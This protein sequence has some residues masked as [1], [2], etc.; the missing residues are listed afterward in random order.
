MAQ[1][2]DRL[3]PF[4]VAMT[5]RV[6]LAKL[7][8]RKHL[9]VTVNGSDAVRQNWVRGKMTAYLDEDEEGTRVRIHA[10]LEVL[11]KLAS[12]G[13]VPIR[14]RAEEVFAEFAE[15]LQCEFAPSDERAPERRQ[16]TWSVLLV[17]VGACGGV[18][19]LLL[20]W[21]GLTASPALFVALAGAAALGFLL[22]W[23]RR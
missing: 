18:L 10:S 17:L 13:A 12:V 6:T 5:V 15:R 11:G 2:S 8:E 22:W 20:Y 23:K 4:Q 3:G 19:G 1:V 9:E 7:E 16:R 21:S 14:R